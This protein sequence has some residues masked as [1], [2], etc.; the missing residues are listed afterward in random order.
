MRHTLGLYPEPETA[1]SSA[2]YFVPL[3][4]Y[5]CNG[6]EWLVENCRGGGIRHICDTYWPRWRRVVYRVVSAS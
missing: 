1:P 5:I 2:V 6:G 3:E 4:G